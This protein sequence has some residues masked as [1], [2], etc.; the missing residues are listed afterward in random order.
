MAFS[1]RLAHVRAAA[2]A[3]ALIA[4]CIALGVACSAASSSG[5]SG[6]DSGPIDSTSPDGN[7]GC[8]AGTSIACAGPGG[9][10]GYQVCNQS[11]SGFDACDCN[12]EGGRD[13]API[14]ASSDGGG[15]QDA[16]Q[17]C[18]AVT[19]PSTNGVPCGAQECTGD[20]SACC[21]DWYDGAAGGCVPPSTLSCGSSGGSVERCDGPEDCP[22]GQYCMAAPGSY[23]TATINNYG[24]VLC[25]GNADCPS[26]LPACDDR[27][28][29]TQ[30]G[31]ESPPYF[32]RVCTIPCQ[33]GRDCVNSGLEVGPY[34]Y[35][36][37]GCQ[38]LCH[39]NPPPP[40]TTC[41]P[42]AAGY[43]QPGFRSIPASGGV[44]S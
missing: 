44:T 2:A 28:E 35:G 30:V 17:N 38:P 26:S 10:S 9:C 19:D 39:M 12:V 25:H 3:L 21:H 13:A 1:V 33:V 36:D 5:A 40:S 15:M 22:M 20:A 14:D 31:P 7:H 27:H 4:C 8:I 32:V 37:P 42:V 23:C 43:F 11:G 16:P 34:C 24:Y 29:L 6:Q 41:T 18:M